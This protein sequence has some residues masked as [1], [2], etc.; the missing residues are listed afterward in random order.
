MQGTYSSQKS[1]RPAQ[2]S[3]LV[4]GARE[5][6]LGSNAA[7]VESGSTGSHWIH[8]RFAESEDLRTF[9]ANRSRDGGVG[10]LRVSGVNEALEM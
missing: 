8:A 10:A 3:L 9:Q 5:L 7:K 4:R 6:K 1:G 2:T